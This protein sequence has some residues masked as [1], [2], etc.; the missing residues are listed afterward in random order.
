MNRLNFSH[1][2][3]AVKKI[4][5]TKKTRL[6]KQWTMCLIRLIIAFLILAISC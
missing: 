6:A 4:T 5:M 3:S 1:V 2:W